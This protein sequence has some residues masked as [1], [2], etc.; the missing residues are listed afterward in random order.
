MRTMIF[1]HVPQWSQHQIN[2]TS[3]QVRNMPQ[4]RGIRASNPFQRITP[5]LIEIVFL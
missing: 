1:F 3:I 5:L 2:S 4:T